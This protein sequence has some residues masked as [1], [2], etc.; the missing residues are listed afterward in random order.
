M[1]PVQDDAAPTLAR[2]AAA[3]RRRGAMRPDRRRPRDVRAPHAAPR[4]VVVDDGSPTAAVA[5]RPR[6]ALVR[7]DRNG[8]PAAARNTG[9]AHVSTAFVAFLD[10][11]SVPP[12]DWIERLAR[13]LRRPARRRGRAARPGRSGSLDMGPHRDRAVR[14]ERRADRAHG[15]RPAS[16]RRC[17]TART[18][19]WS[20]G[21]VDA[22]WRVRLRPAASSST[23]TTTDA[24][25]APVPLRDVGRAAAPRATPTRLRHVVA[26]ARARPPRPPR[27][28]AAR[29]TAASAP[30]RRRARCWT[31]ARRCAASCRHAE[32]PRPNLAGSV[33]NRASLSGYEYED[34]QLSQVRASA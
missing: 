7:R 26:P 14:A 16:T 5:P 15:A 6:R 18:S 27:G 11:D 19:T 2:C 32:A 29:R 24:L 3:L 8:G 17:A 22:G 20:G 9:L 30:R 13:A 28:D 10:A 25:D 34:F 4:V 23:T 12:P 33:W 1:I 31:A 21:C